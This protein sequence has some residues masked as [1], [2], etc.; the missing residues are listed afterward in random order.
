MNVDQ[1]SER[2]QNIIQQAIQLAVQHR[3]P[4]ITS[5]HVL[6][7]IVED[8]TSDG[9]WF[10][11]GIDKEEIMTIIN[12][13]LDSIA[14]VSNYQQPNI[15]HDV[16]KA[17]VEA[18]VWSKQQGDSYLS[19]AAVLIALLFNNST[20]SKEIIKKTGIT[21]DK[22][23]EVELKRRKGRRARFSA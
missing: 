12:R 16:N 1:M 23:I 2:L 6:K 5:A 15:N 17:F 11:L 19:V 7:A 3:H 21:K 13:N 4:E 14:I 22:L 10:D 18:Q 20:V 9:L 8:D